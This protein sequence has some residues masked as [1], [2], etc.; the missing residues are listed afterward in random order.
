MTFEPVQSYC[1]SCKDGYWLK[2]DRCIEL[3]E[4]SHCTDPNMP[5]EIEY[6]G[7]CVGECPP[8]MYTE[9]DERKCQWKKYCEV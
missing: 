9:N 2:D 6:N 8:R 4:G 5:Y 1:I 7:E 3:H